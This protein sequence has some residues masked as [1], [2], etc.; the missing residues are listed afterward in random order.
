MKKEKG[1]HTIYKRLCKRSEEVVV[2]KVEEEEVDDMYLTLSRG[3][4]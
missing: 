4:K 1:Q 3:K 2:V